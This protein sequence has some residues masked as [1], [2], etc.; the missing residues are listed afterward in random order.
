[1]ELLKD[2]VI[3]STGK[4]RYSLVRHWDSQK[5]KA[6]FI[7]LNP[8]TADADIDDPTIR[9]CIGFAKS[10]GCGALEVVNLFAYRATNPDELRMCDDPIGRENDM[11]I[12]RAALRADK[13]IL[14]WG[15]KGGLLGRNGK[16]MELLQ[17]FAWVYCL[18]RSKDGHPK[19]PLYIPANCEL[20]LFK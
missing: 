14:A 15:T 13:I 6:L 7:M 19:H 9:R 1:M 2:A 11:H 16:V 3:D 5:P 10:W 18:D 12:R 17:S 8:S 20:K 4:Y